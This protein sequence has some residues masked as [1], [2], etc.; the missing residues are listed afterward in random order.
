MQQNIRKAL[1]QYL[2]EKYAEQPNKTKKKKNVRL[3]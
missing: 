2:L 3:E 1:K